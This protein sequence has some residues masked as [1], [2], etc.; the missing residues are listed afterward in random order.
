MDK[1][2]FFETFIGLLQ[3]IMNNPTHDQLS[4]SSKGEIALMIYISDHEN[5]SPGQ[6]IEVLK[7]G[8]GRVANALKNLEKKDYII[9]KNANDDHRKTIIFLTEKGKN[10]VTK[11]KEEGR[12]N[13][14]SIYDALGEEDSEHLL[15]IIEK[16]INA[17]EGSNV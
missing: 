14:F 9:R 6:L 16:L 3:R 5:V 13:I 8:S 2:N 1:E 17:K 15:R 12:K 10:F 4:N 11:S 7:V